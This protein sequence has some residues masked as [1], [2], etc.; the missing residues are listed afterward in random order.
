V[1]APE[2]GTRSDA[3]W[4]VRLSSEDPEFTS[5]PQPVRTE[6]SGRSPS[7]AFARPGAVLLER[8]EPASRAQIRKIAVAGLL[9]LGA[10]AHEARERG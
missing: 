5:D 6:T 4:R 2:P 9:L 3:P 10:A 8:D 7:G 1:A